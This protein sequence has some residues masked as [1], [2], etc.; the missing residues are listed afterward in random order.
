MIEIKF[1]NHSFSIWKLSIDPDL[2]AK[3]IS[4]LVKEIQF[5]INKV[6]TSSLGWAELD[7]NDTTIALHRA[8]ENGQSESSPILSFH[9]DDVYATVATL[10]EK[11]A[12]LDGNVREHSFEKA[13]TMHT[14]DRG[15]ISLL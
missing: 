5:T 12:T 10:E 6:I 9:V 15:I 1:Q 11:G 3:L 14:S 4:H 2:R 7:A 13:A 8:S